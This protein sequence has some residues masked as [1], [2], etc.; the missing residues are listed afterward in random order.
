[1]EEEEEETVDDAPFGTVAPFL[2]SACFFV[3]LGSPS[4][5]SGDRGSVRELDARAGL[6]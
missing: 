6:A 1:M 3:S 4:L 2:S 5:L